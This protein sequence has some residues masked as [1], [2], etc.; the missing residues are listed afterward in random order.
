MVKDRV[1][2]ADIEDKSLEDF[3]EDSRNEDPENPGWLRLVSDVE[4]GKVLIRKDTC[5]WADAMEEFPDEELKFLVC[6]YGDYFSIKMRNSN[7]ELT[8][9][10]SIAGGHPYCDCV[11][12]DTR[13]NDKLEHPSDDFFASLKPTGQIE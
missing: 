6:C 12:H 7:F 5:L 4:D 2:K 3:S 1:A 13:I 9:E 10:H 11:I 8:M